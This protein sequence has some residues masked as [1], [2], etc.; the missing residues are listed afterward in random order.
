MDYYCYS[1]KNW[2]GLWLLIFGIGAGS[3]NEVIVGV[4]LGLEMR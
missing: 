4:E 3:G 1:G 2:G